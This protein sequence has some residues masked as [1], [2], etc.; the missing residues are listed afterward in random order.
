V[1][2][3]SA[4]AGLLVTLRVVRPADVRAMVNNLLKTNN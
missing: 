2:Q 3:A 4:Y 1:L